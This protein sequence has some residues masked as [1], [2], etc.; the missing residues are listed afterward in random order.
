VYVHAS[1]STFFVTFD[2]AAISGSIGSSPSWWKY[3]S[4][5]TSNGFN[6]A[7]MACL[8]SVMRTANF[9]NA[10]CPLFGWPSFGVW[11]QTRRTILR[12]SDQSPSFACGSETENDSRDDRWKDSQIGRFLASA[13]PLP[14]SRGIVG[15]GLSIRL[16]DK[17]EATV[18]YDTEHMKVRAAWK[19]G[20]LGFTP[21]R[22]GLISPPVIGGKPQF[23]AA[24]GSGW[25]QAKAAYTGLHLNGER[26]VLSYQVTPDGKADAVVVTETPW[27]VSADGISAFTRTLELGP[28]SVPLTMQLADA[29]KVELRR[30]GGRDVAFLS[31]DDKASALT[32]AITLAADAGIKLVAEKGTVAIT[33]P[34]HRTPLR[35]TVLIASVAEADLGKFAV[36][37]GKEELKG[38][39]AFD[40][41]KGTQAGPARWTA[42]I[43]TK[44]QV[45]GEA[46][47]YV[48]DTIVLP[49]DNPYKA[50][51][52]V[53]GHDFFA[54]G[55]AALCTVH[56]DVWRVSGVDRK[57]DKLTW[58]RFA[59]GLFQPLGLKIVD[60]KVHVL[61]RDQITRLHDQNGDGEAD[62]YENFCNLMRTSSGGHDYTTCLET[63]SAGNFVLMTAQD[64]VVRVSKDGR[65]IETVASG[66]RNPN[67]MGMGPGDIV[68]VAPQEGQ[69][70]PASHI[71]E[72][73]PGSYHGFGGPRVKADRPLGYDP[74]LCWIPRRNDNSSGGQVWVEGKRWG[75]L[76]GQ[77]LHLSYGQCRVLLT[78]REKLETPAVGG[79]A[80]VQ[81]GTVDLPPVFT[82]GVMRGRFS[83]HDGQLY[84]SGLRGWTTAAIHDGCLQRL[85]YTGKPVDLPVG[86]RTMKNGLAITFSRPLDRQE[87][88]DPDNFHVQQWN[89]LYS[90]KYGSAEYK[91]SNP[92]QE[93]RDEA[94]VVSTTL[95]DERT[96]F[97]EI[98][99][100]KPAM[101]TAIGYTLKAKDG[102]ALRHRI[103]YTIHATS[104]AGIDGSKLVRK[105]R[106]GQLSPAEEKAL[107]AGL[108]TRFEQN[109]TRDARDSRL[110]AL[111]VA[112]GA[113]ATPFLKPGPFRATFQGYIRMPLRG[114]VAF[115]LRGQGEAALRINGKDVLK[116]TG[117]LGAQT[118]VR[119]VLHRGLNPISLEYTSP[120]KG[121]AALRLLWQ[122][123]D[124]PLEAVP[125][126]MFQYKGDDTALSAAVPPRRGRELFASLRCASCHGL[127]EGVSAGA[128][129]MPELST[130]GPDLGGAG[131]RLQP[132]WVMQWLLDPRGVQN[133]AT[134]PK[135]F[136]SRDD[137]SRQKAADLAAYVA[138]LKPAREDKQ[139]ETAGKAATGRLLFE[140]LNCLVC[141]KLTAPGAKDEHERTS[142]HFVGAKF[143]AGELEAFLRKPHSHHTWGRM[144]DFHLSAEEA[145]SLSAALKED[146]KGTLARAKELNGA[147]AKRGKDLFASMRCASCHTVGKEKIVSPAFVPLKKSDGGCLGVESAGRG[148]VPD[149]ALAAADRAALVEFLATDRQSLARRVPAEESRRLVQSLRCTSCHSRDAA[150]SPHWTIV[151]DEG[152][153]VAP[154]T[155]PHLTWAGEKLRTGWTKRFIAGEVPYRVRPFLKSRMPSFPAYADVLAHGVAAEHGLAPTEPAEPALD[156]ELV[157]IGNKLTF[158][159]ALDCRQCHAVGR[160]PLLGDKG[161]QVAVGINFAHV[162]ERL[163]PEFYTRVVLDPVRYDPSSKMPKFIADLKTTKVT[164]IFGGDASRQLGAIWQFIQTVPPERGPEPAPLPKGAAEPARSGT[165]R[166]LGPKH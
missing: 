110:A 52:F 113:A 88:E 40:F 56:G 130:T 28:S 160:E 125:P 143:R 154:E 103:N 106:P 21:A 87:A 12:Y 30:E 25:L 34:A 133:H 107:R 155:L 67:G 150:I 141:H 117:D 124:F 51:F 35:F 80:F 53:G 17:Q 7:V 39:A 147:D 69:W 23:V 61:G 114:D 85:R 75:P 139:P 50:L 71:A 135:L 13:L 10:S 46:G 9:P 79:S 137:A 158:K 29:S 74:P 165:R 11:F 138:S 101:Q 2:S 162:R 57:L 122:G 149:F 131:G 54:N 41:K 129:A 166:G 94:E 89:Y 163:R 77:M 37:A 86:V 97:I 91:L 136:D 47:P 14:Y 4:S 19:D 134:M 5:V 84:V 120:A 140:D 27:L 72:V 152:R 99:D 73:R 112:D 65:K 98:P 31:I 26:V 92:K 6:P 48:V 146:A 109:G 132:E 59:T 105:P 126:Q 8:A 44:G 128:G 121:E 78:L 156:K 119:A 18:C 62:Y 153:G 33:V 60:D 24:Q 115:S 81:G 116:T 45:S 55:D 64:G 157:E 22:F 82:S 144:P 76:E 102:A 96:V 100:L 148:A 36:L 66:F 58:K 49:F 63:D 20:F 1:G 70:T 93:G 164:T 127:P 145:G 118:P 42:P 111:H 151:G 15:K 142:L 32:A 108:L 16:G 95:L 83:P 43:V 90:E 104:A 3:S 161:T 68:T 38:E 123:D 159:T